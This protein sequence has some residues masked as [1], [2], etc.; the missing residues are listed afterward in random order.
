MSV[1]YNPTL[2]SPEGFFFYFGGRMATTLDVVNECLASM[3]ESPLNALAEPHAFKTSALRSLARSSKT[4]QSKGWWYNTEAIT[5]NASPT[6]GYI[7]LPGDCLKFQTGQ[8]AQDTLVR[9]QP[10]PWIVQ[11]GTR[12]YDTRTRSFA[13][14]GEVIGEIVRDIPFDDLP[15]VMNDY[16]AADAILRFQSSFDADNSK[17]QELLQTLGQA[18][19]EARAENIRQLGVNL[20]NSN[21]RLARIKRVMR[22]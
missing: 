5:L 1:S 6:T 17:R 7:Q 4:I 20:L 8:R 10:M 14:E 11:R 21:P 18:A 13:I 22:R 9:S 16:I 2:P 15:T 19:V 12:L 3:G